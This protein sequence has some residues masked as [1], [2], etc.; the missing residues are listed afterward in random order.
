[1]SLS[2]KPLW[3]AW[4]FCPLN[5][6]TV[7]KQHEND[8]GE[9]FFI[10]FSN[11]YSLSHLF[12]LITLCNSDTE[13]CFFPKSVLLNHPCTNT[14]LMGVFW[15]GNKLLSSSPPSLSLFFA[16]VKKKKRDEA[17]CLKE[18]MQ[19]YSALEVAER[20]L[21]FAFHSLSLIV[22]RKEQRQGKRKEVRM[23]WCWF[24]L[25]SKDWPLMNVFRALCFVVLCMEGHFLLLK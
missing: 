6:Q 21:G 22:I 7:S 18:Y 10:I 9:I 25:H 2:R 3:S 15:Q 13:I 1:M 20:C 19:G 12:I 8:T 17:L 24:S 23:V 4:W 16:G 14:Q 11:H 5:S